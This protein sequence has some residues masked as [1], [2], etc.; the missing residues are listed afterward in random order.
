MHSILLNNA[1]IFFRF[2]HHHEPHCLEGKLKVTK[3][4][5][6][7]TDAKYTADRFNSM[8]LFCRN[9][10]VGVFG[11]LE[12]FVHGMRLAMSFLFSVDQI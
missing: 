10:Q 2:S 9:S 8:K 5:D 3:F 11:C 12:L 4:N 6:L 7:L 1:E